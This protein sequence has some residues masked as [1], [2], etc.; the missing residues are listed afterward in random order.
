[1]G[2]SAPTPDM[3]RVPMGTGLTGWVAEHDQALLVGDAQSDGRSVIVGRVE[4]PESMLVVPMSFEK[5]NR[6]VIVL[7]RL[8]LDTFSADDQTTLTIFAGYAAQALVN[9][10][11]MEQLHLQRAE[12]EHQLSGQRRLMAVNERLLSTLD[13]ASVLEL[14][15]D[16]LKAVVTYDSLTIYRVDLARGVRYPVIAR[17]R[18]ADVILEY[19]APLGIGIT[20]WS[21]EHR[22][23]VLA[24]DA[25]KDPRSVQIPGTPIEPESLIVVPLIVQG[26]V[27]GTLNVARI[28]EA[29]SHFSENEFELT[30][31]FAAQAAIALRNAE[32]HGEVKVQ[33]ERDALTGLRNHGAFQRELS[34]SIALP[35]AHPLAV[36][37]M[38][39][40]RFKTYNDTHGHPAGD[41]LLAAVA[42]A[43]EGAIRT[44]DS[45]YRYGGDEF[46][47][48]LPN[49]ERVGAE[50]V[51]R[52]IREAV[53][54]IHGDGATP[55]VSIS[56]GVGCL[57]EDGLDRDCPHG[58]CR[59]G[60]LFAKGR[61]IRSIARDPVV[62]ALDETAGALLE[63][64]GFDGADQ[65]DPGPRREPP[66]DRPRLSLSRPA[67]RP[68]SRGPGRDRPVRCVCRLH[69]AGR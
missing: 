36:L 24:N 39:L 31:L 32:T 8:G 13:A 14:V 19:E 41:D 20:G 21:V 64:D 35:D 26:E 61:R 46:T 37:M 12:L 38:D 60:A 28:G 42:R 3:L 49:T 52:R 54:A 27:L 67:G 25:I 18:F 47:V 2:T 51:A 9:A 58:G 5:V 22:E 65:D 30:K 50:E 6:G 23:A 59:L 16:S 63:R 66:R 44:A 34:L 1:M 55:G 48:I 4:G 43:V 40:D 33:A 57:P 15:A 7:S 53:D 69:D 68:A 11:R 17:D 45:A 56:V 29:E 62:A 10:E